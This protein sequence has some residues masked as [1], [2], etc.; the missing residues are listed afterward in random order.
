MSMTHTGKVMNGPI[1]GFLF[2]VLEGLLLHGLDWIPL[3]IP[4]RPHLCTQTGSNDNPWPQKAGEAI[5]GP[6]RHTVAVRQSSAYWTLSS[7]LY[8]PGRSVFPAWSARG[9]EKLQ[10]PFYPGGIQFYENVYV[11]TLNIKS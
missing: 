11:R 5:T 8:S 3:S 4:H 2:S 1:F 7:L 9:S 10:S 6:Q